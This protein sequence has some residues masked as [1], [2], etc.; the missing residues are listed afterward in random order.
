MTYSHNLQHPEIRR[1]FGSGRKLTY[2]KGEIIQHANEP[3]QGVYFIV[4]GYVKEYTLSKN[5]TEHFNIMYESGE[6][7]SFLWV[8]LDARQNVYREAHTNTTVLLLGADELRSAMQT[9]NALWR[10][11]SELLMLQMYF[12]KLRV[13]NLAFSNAYDKVAYCMLYFAG[14]YGDERKNGWYVRQPFRHQHIADSLSMTRETAS[15][16]IARME[17]QGL[18]SQD[19]KGHFTIRNASALAYTIGV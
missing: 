12:L 19:T 2:K 6:I 11:I 16:M 8:Y 9:N 1:L 10:E 15:R 4:S 13:E 5:G 17:R 7:F 3:P 18:I 14:R